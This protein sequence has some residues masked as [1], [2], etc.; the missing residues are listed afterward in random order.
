[1]LSTFTLNGQSADSVVGADPN[2]SDMKSRSQSTPGRLPSHATVRRHIDQGPRLADAAGRRPASPSVVRRACDAGVAQRRRQRVVVTETREL[3][4][5]LP[6]LR[7]K[8]LDELL[9][10]TTCIKV[11]RMAATFASSMKLLWATLDRKHSER[12][13]GGE[14]WIPFAQS[15]ERLDLRRP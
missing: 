1:M 5:S 2:L 10:H 8:V 15:G 7:E 13:G 9:M 12:I 6:G 11:M 3:E 4:E 14:R